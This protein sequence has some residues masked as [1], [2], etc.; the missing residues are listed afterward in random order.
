MDEDDVAALARH[1]QDLWG[2]GAGVQVHAPPPGPGAYVPLGSDPD[3]PPSGPLLPRIRFLG[4]TALG[5]VLAFRFRWPPDEVDRD[6]LLLL[7]FRDHPGG[8]TGASTW[9]LEHVEQ[10][11]HHDTTW[12]PRDLVPISAT[13]AVVRT[14]R[15]P[16]GG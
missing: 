8:V 14:D 11:I 13:A 7:D 2:R 15:R 10:R 5:T 3:A 4:A 12:F 6:L 9:L 1:E 16:G